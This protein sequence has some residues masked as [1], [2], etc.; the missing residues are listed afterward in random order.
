MSA[1]K[2][3]TAPK[4][5]DGAIEAIRMLRVARTGAVKAKPLRATLR[6]MLIPAPYPLR[7]HLC[8]LSAT[9]LT[10]RVRSDPI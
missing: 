3:S 5:A 2:A 6:A 1:G 7:S 10:G 4:R 8:G 9:Q